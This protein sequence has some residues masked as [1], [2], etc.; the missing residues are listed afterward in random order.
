[1]RWW[2]ALP[3]IRNRLRRLSNINAVA[4]QQE[5][6]KGC[7]RVTTDNGELALDG[8]ANSN[9]WSTMDDEL[10]PKEV[11]SRESAEAVEWTGGKAGTSTKGPSDPPFLFPTLGQIATPATLMP[12]ANSRCLRCQ[13][14][15]PTI[16]NT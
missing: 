14:R 4:G 12:V 2:E 10:G 16:F 7:Q 6:R 1:V 15:G 9:R 13:D 5:N 3:L 11:S 8:G